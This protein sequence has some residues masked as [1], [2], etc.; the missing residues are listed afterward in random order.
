MYGVQVRIR[1]FL[2]DVAS[3]IVGSRPT[4]LTSL[5]TKRNLTLYGMCLKCAKIRKNNCYFSCQRRR[6]QQRRSGCGAGD[7]G[8]G[9]RGGRGGRD[10]GGRG[11]GGRRPRRAALRLGAP[12]AARRTR[13][14]RQPQEPH[15]AVGGPAHAGLLLSPLTRRCT[16]PA[17]LLSFS[18]RFLPFFIGNVLIFDGAKVTF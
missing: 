1:D 4:V 3:L 17:N 8:R 11:G 10:G 9:R 18:S 15:H 14:L 13:L 7:T 6:R 2:R 12:R 16:E 5:T